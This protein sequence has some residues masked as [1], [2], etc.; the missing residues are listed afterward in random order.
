MIQ[1]ATQIEKYPDPGETNSQVFSVPEL[2]I[3]SECDEVS[4][5][6][7]FIDVLEDISEFKEYQSYLL[8]AKKLAEEMEQVKSQLFSNIS[9]EIR[10]PINSIIGFSELLS[11]E[12]LTEDQKDYVKII[13]DS[14]KH[15]LKLMNNLLDFSNLE[16]EAIELEI[17]ECSLG[18]ILS[19]V[20]SVAVLEAEKK[21]LDFHIHVIDNTATHLS[22][23]SSRLIQCLENLTDNAIKFTEKGS[24]CVTVSSED[25]GELEQ[26]HFDVEDTG[27][28]MDENEQKKMFEPFAQA[29]K[30]PACELDGMGLGL[31]I[32]QKLIKL[33]GGK[34]SVESH[35]GKGTLFSFSLPV[36]LFLSELESNQNALCS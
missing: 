7:D 29:T 21:G 13:C 9:H 10:T 22:T 6:V 11:D 19:E 24:V 17:A 14:G 18:K 32:T 1:T 23:D 12:S 25:Q 34:L 28:G 16:T 26:I 36:R 4:Q 30:D 15:L 8:Q 20:E 5:T 31:A 35:V 33:L 27:I 2:L 3:S